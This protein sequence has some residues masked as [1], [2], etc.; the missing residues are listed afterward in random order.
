MPGSASPIPAGY[1]FTLARVERPRNGNLT[2]KS[3][4][5]AG[6]NIK[7]KEGGQRKGRKVKGGEKLNKIHYIFRSSKR[8][9]AESGITWLEAIVSVRE[10]K[11]P[12][13]Q[14]HC[15]SN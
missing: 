15:P 13:N 10:K 7:K 11:Q 8:D 6:N 2:F 12:T 9:G 3:Y 14:P 5:N 1:Y 4:H